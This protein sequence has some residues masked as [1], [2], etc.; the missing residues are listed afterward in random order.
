MKHLS[1]RIKS[2]EDQDDPKAREGNENIAL[3]RTANHPC[4]GKGGLFEGRPGINFKLKF[5]LSIGPCFI[6]VS[7]VV[8]ML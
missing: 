7:F 8:W 3:L 2:A 5:Y 1:L 4:A 6:V